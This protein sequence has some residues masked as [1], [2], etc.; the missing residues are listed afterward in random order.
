MPARSGAAGTKF[1]VM[2]TNCKSGYHE[3]VSLSAPADAAF[4][5]LQ[6]HLRPQCAFCDISDLAPVQ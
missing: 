6:M 2:Q 4:W 3:G 1:P 5:H